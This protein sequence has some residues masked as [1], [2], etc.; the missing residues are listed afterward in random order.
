MDEIP[1]SSVPRGDGDY[2][3]VKRRI[4]DLALSFMDDLSET[5]GDSVKVDVLAITAMVTFKVDGT[6]NEHSGAFYRCEDERAW[7]QGA[8]FREAMENADNIPGSPLDEL[9]DGDDDDD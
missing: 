6:D 4:G 2:D 9:Q 5:F 1:A 8:V 7:V 3:A